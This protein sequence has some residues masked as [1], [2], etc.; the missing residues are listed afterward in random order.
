MTSPSHGSTSS[1]SR[2]TANEPATVATRTF[3]ATASKQRQRLRGGR[4]PAGAK[5]ALRATMYAVANASPAP[6][7]SVPSGAR[8]HVLAPPAVVDGRAA[9]A[10][11]DEHLAHAERRRGRRAPRPPRR[12]ASAPRC[13]E[14]ARGR[15]RRR[16]A[17]ARAR[18]TRT[19]PCP[20]NETRRRRASAAIVSTGNSPRAS[21]ATC[22]QRPD[23]ELREVAGLPDVAERVDRHR[24]HVAVVGERERRGRLAARRSA[25]ASRGGRAA[26]GAPRGPAPRSARSRAQARAGAAARGRRGTGRLRPAAAGR[27]GGRARGSR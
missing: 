24:A 26:A 25:P 22:A 5:P 1:V 27:A 3:I 12:R 20:S 14:G 17:T 6:V 7:G 9:R 15:S 11:R 19:S 10:V 18:G 16:A 13:G 23:G 21:G 2:S 4:R 8:R